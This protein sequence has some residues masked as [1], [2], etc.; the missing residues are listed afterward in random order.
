MTPRSFHSLL[1][2]ALFAIIGCNNGEETEDRLSGVWL[3]QVTQNDQLTCTESQAHNYTNALEQNNDEISPWTITQTAEVSD[4][5]FFAQIED[6]GE[7]SAVL[8]LGDQAWPGTKREGIVTFTWTDAETTTETERHEDDGYVFIEEQQRTATT[9]ITFNRNGAQATG[10][11]TLRSTDLIDWTESETWDPKLTGFSVSQ[12]PS[13]DYIFDKSGFGLTNR[14]DD[15]DCNGDSCQ[16]N[17]ST[18]CEGTGPFTAR[19]AQFDEDGDYDYLF[20]AGT[21]GDNR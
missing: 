20:D 18:N 5:L 19:R 16:L 3:F 9:T 17:Q 4:D 11:A 10:E 21:V 12:I 15:S 14:A 1:L 13:S 2:P 7:N 6:L 8:I